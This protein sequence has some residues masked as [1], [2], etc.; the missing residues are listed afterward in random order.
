M[1]LVGKRKL[2]QVQL[3]PSGLLLAESA[4]VNDGYEALHGGGA[5]F[6]P[7]GVYRFRSSQEADAH[8][9]SCRARGMARLAATRS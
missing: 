8:R 5:T 7:K 4:R 9:E 3:L 1:R 2:R 6:I